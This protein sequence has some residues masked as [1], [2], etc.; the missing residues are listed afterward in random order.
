[1]SMH[2][3]CVS[4]VRSVSVPMYDMLMWYTPVSARTR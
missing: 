4:G 3:V 1:M 2:N